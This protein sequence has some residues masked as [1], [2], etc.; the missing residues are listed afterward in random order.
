MIERFGPYLELATLAET[1]GTPERD[2]LRLGPVH[3]RSR[4]V[5]P[6]R[7]AGRD[8][9]PHASRW[10]ARLSDR[11][12]GFSAAEARELLA[13]IGELRGARGTA[14]PRARGSGPVRAVGHPVRAPDHPAAAG[15][16]VRPRRG[17]AMVL[18]EHAAYPGGEARARWH[19]EEAVR[20][21]TRHLRRAA[22]RLLAGGRGDQRSH[23]AAAG[24]RR[25]LPLGRQQRRR[26]CAAACC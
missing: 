5:V 6:P 8:R 17:A 23:A 16:Q 20:I 13:L 3:A 7:L 4:G 2:Q 25:R 15:L 1:L 22:G 10:S 24:L 11:G 19:I 14:L 9:A 21:F 18:P 26:C 12:R